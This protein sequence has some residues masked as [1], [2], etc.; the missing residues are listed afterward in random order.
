MFET[1]FDITIFDDPTVTPLFYS[2]DPSYL[3][4][5]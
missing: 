1:G 4:W 5:I 3:D 2:N